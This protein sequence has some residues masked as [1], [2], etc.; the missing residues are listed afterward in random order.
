M[1]MLHFEEI[2]K[3]DLKVKCTIPKV[4]DK[5]SVHVRVFEGNKERIQIFQGVVL[6][7]GGKRLSRSFTVRKISD[8]IGVEKTFP[9]YSPVLSKLEIV[10]RSKVRRSKLYYTRKLQ[11]RASRLTTDNT[12]FA[13]KESTQGS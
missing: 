13:K 9:I 6:K 8:G 5:V 3:K 7:L 12:A 10:S 11:G 4:G 1:S 2:L